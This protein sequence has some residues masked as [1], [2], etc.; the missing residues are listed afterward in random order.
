[1]RHRRCSALIVRFSWQ[2]SFVRGSVKP[3]TTWA[4]TGT[5]RR[6]RGR[7]TWLTEVWRRYPSRVLD[8]TPGRSLTD[9]KLPNNIRPR[10]AVY[11]TSAWRSEPRHVQQQ[12]GCWCGTAAVRRRGTLVGSLSSIARGKGLSTTTDDISSWQRPPPDNRGIIAC[13]SVVDRLQETNSTNLSVKRNCQH[14]DGM[15]HVR[16]DDCRLQLTANQEITE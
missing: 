14:Y 9:G 3:V 12:S 16:Y 13:R 7:C 4:M 8:Y 15:L 10:K 11:R 1:M 6:R 2:H 5:W